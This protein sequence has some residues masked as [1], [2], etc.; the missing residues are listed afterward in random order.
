MNDAMAEK[1]GHVLPT[2]T[3]KEYHKLYKKSIDDIFGDMKRHRDKRGSSSSL[4]P[5]IVSD[6]Q[7]DICDAGMEIESGHGKNPDADFRFVTK[8]NTD[9]SSKGENV[10][11][12]AGNGGKT[13]DAVIRPIADGNTDGTSQDRNAPSETDMEIES[14]QGKAPDAVVRPIAEGNTDDSSQDRNAQNKR[15]PQRRGRLPE[16]EN[17]SDDD[18]SLFSDDT[19]GNDAKQS[20]AEKANAC[21]DTNTEILHAS[22]NHNNDGTIKGSRDI[23]KAFPI[24]CPVLWDLDSSSFRRGMVTSAPI[25]DDNNDTTTYEVM[26]T[27]GGR[28]TTIPERS[29]AY[30]LNCPVYV[31]HGSESHVLGGKI[32]FCK[33]CC[34][35]SNDSEGELVSYTILIDREH[36]QFQVMN[37]IPSERVK[38]REVLQAEVPVHSN[39]NAAPSGRGSIVIHGEVPPQ[40][41]KTVTAGLAPTPAEENG[42]QMSSRKFFSSNST[43]TSLDSAPATSHHGRVDD[44]SGHDG[45][46]SVEVYFP[47]WLVHDS[48]S[49]QRLISYLLWVDTKISDHH[50]LHRIG[51]SSNCILRIVESGDFHV[52]IET[53]SVGKYATEDTRKAEEKLEHALLE[54]IQR[55]GSSGRLFYDMAWSCEFLHPK[56]NAQ[57]T[58][59]MQRNP[60]S[61]NKEMG[62]MNIVEF[63]CSRVPGTH[64]KKYQDYYVFAKRS[65]LLGRIKHETRCEIKL[66]GDDFNVPTKLCAPYVWVMGHQPGLVDRAVDILRDSIQSHMGM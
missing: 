46:S 13:P 40:P 6:K 5:S 64:R 35:S 16:P 48:A 28:S 17:D 26:P 8:G 19:E 37:N 7:D 15:S 25:H 22:L 38:Y 56:G 66:C 65:G 10:S 2:E 44:T 50:R 36:N 11:N 27:I 18:V 43:I 32:L 23:I 4:A 47:H 20:D 31:S 30:G 55:D 1:W 41:K 58:S 54:Y 59:V 39:E 63:P 33:P 14:G 3:G 12:K 42:S 29:L 45:D 51:R 24:G 9:G 34:P 61:S 62:W 21:P 52:L 60:F 49:K 57:S 53:I